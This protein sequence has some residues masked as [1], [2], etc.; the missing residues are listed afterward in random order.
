[1]SGQGYQT[2]LDCRRR[3]RL[4]REHGFTIDQIAIVLS[5]DHQVSPLRLYRYAA[6]LTARQVVTAHARLDLARAA[7]RED[8][9]YDYERW[10]HSG[11]RP[12]A[13]ALR[14]LARIYGT[15]PA[16]LVPNEALATYPARDQKALTQAE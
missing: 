12:P 3:S 2:L 8:R 1:M 4:L 15:T 10:P 7:L 11:R 5:L 9:L 13:H 16:H 6:G 14:L